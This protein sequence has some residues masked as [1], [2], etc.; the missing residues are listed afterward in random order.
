MGEQGD[1]TCRD[2]QATGW[3]SDFGQE[4]RSTGWA[5][6]QNPDVDTTVLDDAVGCLR[7][8]GALFAYLHGSQATGAATAESDIDLAAF[9]PDP[10][11]AS[12]EI[13]LPAGVDLLVLNGADLE[14]AGR[15]AMDGTL[16]L[17]VD[18][19]ARVRWESRTRKIYCDELYRMERSRREFLE[20]V[21]RG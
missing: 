17:E 19:V 1:G 13:D 8:A 21:T 14:L 3:R 11:P 9:F 12:F 16:V 20:A 15:V 2:R 10:A 4:T 6:C 18:E 7:D 5:A